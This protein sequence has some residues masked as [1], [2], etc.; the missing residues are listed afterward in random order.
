MGIEIE[1]KFLVEGDGWRSAAQGTRYRQGFL[2]TSKSRTVRIRTDGDRGFITVKGPPVGIVRREYEYE[3]PAR[4]A[5][6]IL[7][8][9]C[10]RPIIVKIRY[11]IAL[12]Q[13]TWE[14]DEFLGENEGLIVAEV[15][16]SQEDEPFERPAWLGLE[17]TYDP[18]YYNANLVKTPYTKWGMLTG[19]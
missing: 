2:N 16:L 19:G 13:H 8:A 3:I 11:R 15:E 4:D 14:V 7:E 1:R 6:A 12:G 9:L 17:V 5:D 10:E 18:R